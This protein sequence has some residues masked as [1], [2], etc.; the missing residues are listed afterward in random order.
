[1]RNLT[2][3]EKAEKYVFYRYAHSDIELALK[4]LSLVCGCVNNYIIAALI[5]DAII[6]YSRPFINNK[7]IYRPQGLNL[8][9]SFVP[10][11]KKALHQ[12]ILNL[13]NSIFAHTDLKPKN[14]KLGKIGDSYIITSKGFYH[15]E[16]ISY[17]TPLS[18]LAKEVLIELETQ[19]KKFEK[20]FLP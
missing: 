20:T 2:E 4:S 11:T 16:L 13:R 18:E 1:M 19:M 3:E 7:G 14:P 17:V 5:R 9:L 12:K 6:S 15:E 8:P 10:T